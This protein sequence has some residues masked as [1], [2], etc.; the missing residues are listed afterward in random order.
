MKQ[1]NYCANSKCR[2]P[3]GN[4]LNTMKF[5]PSNKWDHMDKDCKFFQPI[6]RTVRLDQIAR[7]TLTNNKGDK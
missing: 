5:K 4:K 2:R 1:C 7:L 3:S 6:N